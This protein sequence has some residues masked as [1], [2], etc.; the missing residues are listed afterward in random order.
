MNPIL[1]CIN[2]KLALFGIMYTFAVQNT[3]AEAT[4]T[5]ANPIAF[6]FAK[7]KKKQCMNVIFEKILK[8]LEMMVFRYKW[9]KWVMLF[10]MICIFYAYPGMEPAS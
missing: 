9:F 3:S 6:Y 10:S 4:G 2:G 5:T 7:N 1:N 8:I